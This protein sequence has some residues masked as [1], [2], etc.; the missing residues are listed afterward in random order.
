VRMNRKGRWLLQALGCVSLAR[1]LVACSAVDEASFETADEVETARAIRVVAQ[2]FLQSPPTDYA[3]ELPADLRSSVPRD[4]GEPEFDSLGH[5]LYLMP[6]WLVLD[7]DRAELRYTPSSAVHAHFRA[8][9]QL[10]LERVN[11]EWV[12][13]SPKLGS[14]IACRLRR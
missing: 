11:G 10:E 7:G 5:A 9:I 12:I 3:S 1:V 2:R 14:G 13:A 4:I 8:W 6:W